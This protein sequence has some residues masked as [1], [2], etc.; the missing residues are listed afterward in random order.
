MDP[1]ASGTNLV[2]SSLEVPGSQEG[3]LSEI[4]GCEFQNFCSRTVTGPARAMTGLAPE[5]IVPV[6]RDGTGRQLSWIG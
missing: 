6:P 1:P 5:H 4:G 3:V 2:E